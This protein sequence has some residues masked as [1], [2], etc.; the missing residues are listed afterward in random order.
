MSSLP[1]A[2]SLPACHACAFDQKLCGPVSNDSLAGAGTH[3]ARHDQEE[4]ALG[5][6]AAHSSLI[7]FAFAAAKPGLQVRE[8]PYALACPV[9]VLYHVGPP[10][11]PDFTHSSSSSSHSFQH[12]SPTP[13]RSPVARPLE[14]K[15]IVFD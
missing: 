5:C 1:P 15:T 6:P 10:S 7:S 8:A 12:S 4:A 13:A 11:H 14:H 3:P 2:I 9:A